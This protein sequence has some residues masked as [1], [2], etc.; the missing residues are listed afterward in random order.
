[1]TLIGMLSRA[2]TPMR[3]CLT[4]LARVP[5]RYTP[6]LSTSLAQAKSYVQL[7]FHRA[8]ATI[9]DGPPQRDTTPS[10]AAPITEK[11]IIVKFLYNIGSRR[12]VEEYLERFSSVREHQFAVV[13]VCVEWPTSAFIKNPFENSECNEPG[14]RGS[15]G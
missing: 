9:T 6:T 13:K 3:A 4:R 10:L 15:S 11:D 14:G 5:P 1:M 2:G 8:F 12:E 7:P